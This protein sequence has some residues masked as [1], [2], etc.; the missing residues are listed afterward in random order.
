MWTSGEAVFTQHD[1]AACP[2]PAVSPSSSVPETVIPHFAESHFAESQ[3]VES[4]FAESQENPCHLL[5]FLKR[6][7]RWRQT[8]LT[9]TITLTLTDTVTVIF[10]ARF[11]DTGIRRHWIRRNGIRRNGI[12]RNGKTLWSPVGSVSIPVG[13]PA[14]TAE[15]PSSSHPWEPL[16][17]L[18]HLS[19]CH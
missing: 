16:I 4:R 12:R 14:G 13:V 11:V 7:C 10:Y 18:L 9:L 8:K 17:W 2:W 6:K 19:V 5:I 3:F 1:I 15:S